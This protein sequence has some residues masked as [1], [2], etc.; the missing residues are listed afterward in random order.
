MG[1]PLARDMV[2]GLVFK[3]LG[4]PSLIQS[5]MGTIPLF[6]MSFIFGALLYTFS[7]MGNVKIL[8]AYGLFVV[9][10]SIVALMV[11]CEED[12]VMITKYKPSMWD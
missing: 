8:A 11:F 7:N 12:T 3:L 4:L 9:L 10:Y 2:T 6:I 1:A 5:D